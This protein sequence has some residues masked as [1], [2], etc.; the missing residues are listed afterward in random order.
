MAKSTL[1]SALSKADNQTQVEFRLG[2][3]FSTKM[4]EL[5]SECWYC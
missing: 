5:A 2:C 1:V 3:T 4:K